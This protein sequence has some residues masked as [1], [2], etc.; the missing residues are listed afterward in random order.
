MH[1][2]NEPKLL[3]INWSHRISLILAGLLCIALFLLGRTELAIG[4]AKAPYDLLLHAVFFGFLSLLIWYGSVY[5]I[6]LTF[7]LVSSLTIADELIQLGLPGR[8]GSENDVMA[9]LIGMIIVLAASSL[10]RKIM[11]DKG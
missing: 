10:I 2:K 5:K 4:L 7:I 11:S 8:V 6:W 9:G 1:I 3:L